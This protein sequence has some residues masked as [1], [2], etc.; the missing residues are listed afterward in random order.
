MFQIFSRRTTL[1]WSQECGKLKI[2]DTILS[3][4]KM[5][6]E[7][8]KKFSSFSWSRLTCS[9]KFIMKIREN[10]K[11]A[12]VKPQRGI[13]D[14]GREF[15]ARKIDWINFSIFFHPLTL[16]TPFLSPPH[17]R[18]V[19]NFPPKNRLDVS[20]VCHYERNFHVEKQIN[21]RDSSS[22]FP[23]LYF[24]VRK[25]FHLSNTVWGVLWASWISRLKSSTFSAF[26]RSQLSSGVC[27]KKWKS[28]MV[29][30]LGDEKFPAII[31]NVN[32]QE[33]E[34]WENWFFIE[35]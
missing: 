6:I 3:L 34:N 27:V 8:K 19:P 7:S 30:L 23:F 15:Y 24:I 5:K 1:K 33:L 2:Y 16:S 26:K 18:S 9:W 4:V 28:K 17:I 32:S 20:L 35:S 13:V 31:E 21:V 11:E 14:E 10:K 22:N 12:K 25:N 29:E